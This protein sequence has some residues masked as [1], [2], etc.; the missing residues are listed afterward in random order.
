MAEGKTKVVNQNQSDQPLEGQTVA[1]IT[2]APT[3]SR[4]PK[5]RKSKSKKVTGTT[6]HTRASKT[7]KSSK[8]KRKPSISSRLY[9]L[10]DKVGVQEV[11]L[12][13]AI[14]LAK[15]IKPDTAF[16]LKHLAWHKHH[17]QNYVLPRREALA[18]AG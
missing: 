11:K 15:K 13:V 6:S 10:F 18:K 12:D 2:P 3:Q 7:A 8:L 16:N 1:P 14:K 5:S 9:E 4:K 17:Y